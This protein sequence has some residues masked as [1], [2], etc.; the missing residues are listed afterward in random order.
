MFTLAGGRGDVGVKSGI[1][2]LDRMK[3]NIIAK[4][5][6]GSVIL[7]RSTSNFSV[8]VPV[9]RYIIVSA[10]SCGVGHGPITPTPG[11]RITNTG[12]GKT[13]IGIHPSRRRS[14]HP[15]ACH[16]T[17]QGKKSVLGI[18][19]TFIPRSLGTVSTATFSTCL[20]G[21]DGFALCFACLATR[22]DG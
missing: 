20:V 15:I 14:R 7:M 10:S 1:H 16:P 11:R 6:K 21:S 8:P 17:R 12:T 18:V 13:S 4:F 2:F 22:N 3:N 19:L 5:R 9:G